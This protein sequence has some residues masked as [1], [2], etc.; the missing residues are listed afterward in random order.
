LENS[1]K[2]K[3]TNEEMEHMTAISP[4]RVTGISP[5]RVTG[6]S[7]ELVTATTTEPLAAATTE[8]VTTTTT[9]TE[10]LTATTTKPVSLSTI[11]AVAKARRT[12]GRPRIPTSSNL[13]AELRATTPWQIEHMNVVLTAPKPFQCKT[14]LKFFGSK[15]GVYVHI[16]THE[17]PK[18]CCTFCGKRFHHANVWRIHERTHTGEK[19]YKCKYCDWRTGDQNLQ[20]VHERTHPESGKQ[21]YKNPA[22]HRRTMTCPVCQKTV[23]SLADFQNHMYFQHERDPSK[24]LPFTCTICKTTFA[25]RSNAIAH[26]KSTHTEE[27]ERIGAT[28]SASIFKHF[29]LLDKSLL[30]PRG[31][32]EKLKTPEEEIIDD[33]E[34]QDLSQVKIT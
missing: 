30:P 31:R 33:S 3:S 17:E 5:E 25:Y 10:P 34:F 19:P 2:S 8:S 22:H 20:Y 21:P 16:L 1:G 7:P 15:S 32:A 14:C 11:P 9:T 13:P 12:G 29:I 4:E 6:I 18:F 27:M 24:G 23:N 28:N 26:V